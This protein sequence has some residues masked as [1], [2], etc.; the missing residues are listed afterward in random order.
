M[1]KILFFIPFLI[2][3]INLSAQE[4]TYTRQDSL[5]GFLFPERANYDVTFY[6]LNV[7]ID[8]VKKSI[9]G[10]TDIHFKVMEDLPVMQVD[11]FENMKLGKVEWNKKEQQVRREG[12]AFFIDFNQ[13]LKKGSSHIVRINYSG[14]PIIAKRAPW[15]GGFVWSHDEKGN[16]WIGMAVEGDGASLFWPNKDHLSDEP[17]SMMI[18]CTVPTNL[19]CVANGRLRSKQDIKKG[20]TQYNWF[21]SSPINNYNVSLNIGNYSHFRDLH[22]SKEDGDTLTLDYYVMPYNV[23][24]AKVHFKEVNLVLECLEGYFGKY[25]FYEDGYKLVETPYLGM[26]HQSNISYGNKYKKGYLGMD[27]TGLGYDYII[28]HETGHEWFGNSLSMNDIAEMWIHEG[29]TTYADALFV[30]C[31]SDYQTHVKYLNVKKA[32]VKNNHPIIGPLGVNAENKYDSDKYN[33][34]A[35]LLHT[36]RSVVNNDSVWFRALKSFTTDFRHSNVTTQNVIDHFTQETGLKLEPI[37]SQYLFYKNLPVLEYEL[38]QK[39]NST[40]LRY[41]WKT[42]VKDFKMPIKIE[43]G[44]PQMIWITP[45]QEWQ[46]INIGNVTAG[47]LK[48]DTNSFFFKPISV[49]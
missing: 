47:N 29:F 17:D 15:D 35:L 20:K 13:P 31:R 28:Y 7:A 2:C 1:K 48:F 40:F 14:K 11:L 42:D 24:K 36:I 45:N 43:A 38:N 37:F 26:E 49:N 39:E 6:H 44:H 27:M 22:I 32:Q 46:E 33:K 25:P 19:M 4:K 9:E 16:P 5:R 8:T 23:E 21:V 12:N 34:G 30:E 3:L 41:R 10:Y 18:S